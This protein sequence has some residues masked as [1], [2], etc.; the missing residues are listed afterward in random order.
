MSDDSN[1]ERDYEYAADDFLTELEINFTPETESDTEPRMGYEAES[2]FGSGAEASTSA[3]S[4][5]DLF[6]KGLLCPHAHYFSG[7]PG[8][9]EAFLPNI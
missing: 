3:P 8:E 4:D 1:A 2:R 6:D 9:Y 5:A 7:E